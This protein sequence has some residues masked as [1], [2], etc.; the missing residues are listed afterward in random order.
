[1]DA[2][3]FLVSALCIALIGKPETAPNSPEQRQ[4]IAREALEG[5]RVVFTSSILRALALT[6]VQRAFFGNFIG[7]LY[8]IYIVRDLQMPVWVTGVLVGAGGISALLGSLIAERVTRR[9]GIGKSLIGATVITSLLAFLIPLA[10]GPFWMAF[11]VLILSQLG[12][13][14]WTIYSINETSLRQSVTAEH[15][16]G[17]VNASAHFLVGSLGLLGAIVG[18]ILGDLIGVRATLLLGVVGLLLAV[19]WLV[20]SPL[21]R[22]ETLPQAPVTPVE[23]LAESAAD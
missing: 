6:E 13:A 21:R 16:L 7:T 15:Q 3:S 10:G 1:V 14:G 19:L 5:L 8:M 18:G 9:F 22:L 20:F 17:R 23:Q 4:H 2:V 12:D 11:V